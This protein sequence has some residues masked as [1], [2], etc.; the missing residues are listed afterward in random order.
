MEKAENPDLITSLFHREKVL[1]KEGVYCTQ[2]RKRGKT[3]ERFTVNRRRSSR[4]RPQYR[5]R[6]N[7]RD[8]RA[9]DNESTGTDTTEEKKPC[10][11]VACGVGKTKTPQDLGTCLRRWLLQKAD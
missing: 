1:R 2:Q 5:Y 4:V 3:E 7:F 8:W 9:N 6:E 10:R 11:I